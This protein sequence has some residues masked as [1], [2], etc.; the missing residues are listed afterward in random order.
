MIKNKKGGEFSPPM[1]NFSL[2]GRTKKFCV[3]KFS[4]WWGIFRSGIFR[5][6]GEFSACRFYRGIFRS[7]IF[8]LDG[9]FSKWKF[10]HCG[11]FHI[12]IFRLGGEFS[13]VRNLYAA[14][15]FAPMG[16]FPNGNFRR[17]QIWYGFSRWKFPTLSAHFS[18]SHLGIVSDA[19]F[20]DRCCKLFWLQ[21]LCPNW[22]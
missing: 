1:G 5:T 10:P 20:S 11:I 18:A 13:P 3:G 6:C 17:V 4:H 8:R 16:N 19:R 9:E 15:F 7:E 14:T 12:G 22:T 21:K 2:C